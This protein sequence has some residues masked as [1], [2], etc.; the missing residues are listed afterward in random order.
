MCN[1]RPS[2]S[3]LTLDTSGVDSFFWDLAGKRDKQL[4]KSGKGEDLKMKA[5][6]SSTYT[7]KTET[8]V[9]RVLV[10][11]VRVSRPLLYPIGNDT[12]GCALPIHSA[13]PVRFEGKLPCESS[14]PGPLMARI[15]DSYIG[16]GPYTLSY[17]DTGQ[18]Y[19]FVKYTGCH[20]LRRQCA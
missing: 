20:R 10:D 4:E 17:Q 9:N 6:T 16:D 8:D 14:F 3:V 15:P 11:S 2:L 1:Q 5:R 7:S 13:R 19:V 18:Y 12:G